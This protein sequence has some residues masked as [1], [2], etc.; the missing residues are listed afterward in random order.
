[1]KALYQSPTFYVQ[2]ESAKSAVK[3]R[4]LEYCKDALLSPYI[5]FLLTTCVDADYKSRCSDT[6]VDPGLLEFQV[7]ISTQVLHDDATP[8]ST[9][10]NALNKRIYHIENC[11]LH[12]RLKKNGGNAILYKHYDSTIPFHD[13]A[14]S[15]KALGDTLN[16]AVHVAGELSQR[17]QDTKW[18]WLRLHLRKNTTRVQNGDNGPKQTSLQPLD[19]SP[20]IFCS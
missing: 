18:T 19:Y 10:P 17:I 8:F 12:C 6:V 1:M 7:F 16:Y 9:D 4:T 3:H 5:L 13:Q 11:S 20:K 15:A 2:D 14:P